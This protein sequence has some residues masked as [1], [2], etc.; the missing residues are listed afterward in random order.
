MFKEHLILAEYI[1]LKCEW[2]IHQ[3]ITY[4]GQ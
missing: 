4:A 2:N 1:F 3:D